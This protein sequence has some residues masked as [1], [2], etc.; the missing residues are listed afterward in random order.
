[1]RLQSKKTKRERG[2]NL[3]PRN[4]KACHSVGTALLKSVAEIGTQSAM[5]SSRKTLHELT[6][7]ILKSVAEIGTRFFFFFFFAPPRTGLAGNPHR[8]PLQESR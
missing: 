3:S 1:V 2:K 6:S 8:H 5:K 4:R 7:H